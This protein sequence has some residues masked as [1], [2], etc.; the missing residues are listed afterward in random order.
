MPS[1]CESIK[2]STNSTQIGTTDEWT[3]PSDCPENQHIIRVS[4]AEIEADNA[5]DSTDEKTTITTE[6]ATQTLSDSTDTA[7]ETCPDNIY[8]KPRLVLQEVWNCEIPLE[9]RLVMQEGVECSYQVKC[10]TCCAYGRPFLD[11]LGKPIK[12]DTKASP[13][14]SSAKALPAADLTP[15]IRQATGEFWL[16]NARDEHSSVAGFHRFALDLLAHGAPPEFLSRTQEGAAQELQHA[17]DCF[18]LA[19]TY[20]QTPTGPAAMSMGGQAPIAASLAQL[21]AWTARDGAVGETIAAYLASQALLEATDPAVRHALEMIIHDETQHA[22]LAWK[23]IAW[24]ISVG[25]EEVKEAVWQVF[26]E[27]VAPEARDEFWRPEMACHGVMEPAAEA[28][29]AADCIAH[30]ILPVARTLLTVPN[31]VSESAAA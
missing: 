16:R 6:T 27:L 22:Q 18:G 25:G 26:G 15:E 9:Q 23:A 11:T 20:L 4:L 3:S 12:A 30:V 28:K 13:D 24:A 7:M 10:T 21:A 14:W 8:D 19:S 31:F 2:H 1:G 29:A 17:I 5:D